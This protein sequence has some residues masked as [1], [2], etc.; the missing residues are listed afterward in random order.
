MLMRRR[1][2]VHLHIG[3]GKCL[4]PYFENFR[5]LA[6]NVL[7]NGVPEQEGGIL[8]LQT[9]SWSMQRYYLHIYEDAHV[10]DEEGMIFPD[11]QAAKEEAIR[12]A[13]CIMADQVLVGRISLS[14]R[15]EVEDENRRP[16]FTL[17][18]SSALDLDD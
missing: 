2:R 17:P 10:R 9:R 16:L 8:S 15:V 1:P 12:C 18:F 11:V 3:R 14:G 4:W 5:N 13:R 6:K 7:S